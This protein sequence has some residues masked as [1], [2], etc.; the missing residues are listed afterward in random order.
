MWENAFFSFQLR[1]KQKKNY[2]RF[3]TRFVAAMTSA[4]ATLLS[5]GMNDEEM[6][7]EALIGQVPRRATAAVRFHLVRRSGARLSR[8]EHPDPP[9][10]VDRS[11]AAAAPVR[12]R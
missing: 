12:D 3:H 5:V 10:A 2:D 7:Y 1:Q 6:G 8:P 11:S 9:P 4:A